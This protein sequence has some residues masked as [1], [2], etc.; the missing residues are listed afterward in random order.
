M[1][2]MTKNQKRKK[3]QTTVKKKLPVVGWMIKITDRIDHLFW[4]NQNYIAILFFFRMSKLFL[5]FFM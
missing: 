5:A 3:S 1:N 2:K 4:V